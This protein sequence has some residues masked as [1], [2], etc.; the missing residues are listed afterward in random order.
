[1]GAFSFYESVEAAD[2]Y[3]SERNFYLRGRVLF[4]T[5]KLCFFSGVARVLSAIRLCQFSAMSFF[6]PPTL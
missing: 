6:L 5:I 4:G 1:M 3:E 2:I